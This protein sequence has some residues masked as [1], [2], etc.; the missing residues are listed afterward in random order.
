MFKMGLLTSTAMTAVALLLS[1][2]P[3][4]AYAQTDMHVADRD[5]N[6][7][8]LCN[9]G[10]FNVSF[11]Y[12][13]ISGSF[14][15]SAWQEVAVP[16][17]G[18]GQTVRHITVMEARNPRASRYGPFTAG[19][20][21]NRP[22]GFPGALIANGRA[23]A[24]QSCRRIEISIAPTTLQA[25][26]TYWIE[27]RME[28]YYRGSDSLF[29]ASWEINPKA[30]QKAFVRNHHRKCLGGQCSHSYSISSSTTP[31]TKQTQGPWFKLK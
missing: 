29:Q 21:S 17:T 26:T 7:R 18:Q 8:F 6:A 14:I 16:I 2:A 12:N 20:Y 3:T 25:N 15:S 1:G 27:E 22:S 28:H 5:A 19:I 11:L 23:K 13:E 4:G 9:Y 24:P 31:W 30:Q 10:Q